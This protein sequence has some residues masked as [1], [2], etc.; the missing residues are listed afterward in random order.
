[1]SIHT[2]TALSSSSTAQLAVDVTT[3]SKTLETPTRDGAAVSADGSET[4]Y[5]RRGRGPVVIFVA[6]AFLHRGFGPMRKMTNQLVDGFTA[7]TYDRRDRGESTSMAD[8][9]QVCQEFDDL[10]AVIDAN[11]GRAHLFGWSSG[12]SLVLQAAPRLRGVLSIAVYESPYISD[13]S[14]APQPPDYLAR[15]D[16]LVAAGKHAALIGYFMTVGIGLPRA[17][18]ALS[19]LNPQWRRMKALAPTLARDARLVH[20]YAVGGDYPAGTFDGISVPIWIGWGSKSPEWI[21]NSNRRIAEL[22]QDKS[23]VTSTQQAGQTHLVKPAVI[24]PEL[25]SHFRRHTP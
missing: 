11:G 14:R 22:V 9:Y 10:Q 8:E 4:V 1:V 6:G 24:G 18:A 17:V 15:H 21:R 2:T 5:S 19:R 7:V 12:A 23:L 20:P 16:E 25:R 13:S 3:F